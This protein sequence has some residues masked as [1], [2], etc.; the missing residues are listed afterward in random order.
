MKTRI[1]KIMAAGAGLSML[2]G[3]IVL[4]VYPFYN[5]RDLISDASVAGRWVNA[6]NTNEFWQFAAPGEKSYMLTTTDASNT[7]SFNAHLF[8]LKQYEFLDLLTTNR[9]EFELPLHLISMVSH[10]NDTMSL[11]FMD[12]GWL[13]G[14]LE[15]NTA[16]LRHIIVFS[17]PDDTNS[18]KM[19]YLTASTPDL[20]RFLLK[21]AGDTNAFSTGSAV[22]LSRVA[23]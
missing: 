8:Q 20:Q 2:S 13:A 9:G 12:Y 14:L 6:G 7:N 16:A 15:T 3:C 1:L 5:A 22:E 11:R 18:D 21:H 23:Q 19:V 17:N 10:T 4:S